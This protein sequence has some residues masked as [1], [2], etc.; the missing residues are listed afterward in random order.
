MR[1]VRKFIPVLVVVVLGLAGLAPAQVI[2]Q[3]PAN[4]MVVL[5]VSNLDATSKKI[6]DLITSMGLGQMSP[7][8]A[9]PLG[10]AQKSMGATEGI[11]KSGELAIV[12]LDPDAV[13]GD[14]SKAVLALLP[15]SDYQAFLG[16]YQGNKTD[17][18]VTEV[19]TPDSTESSFVA[20]WGNYA[21]I[22]QSKDYLSKKPD[23]FIE[24]DG[25]AAK[26]LENKDMV[27][28]ANVKVL[29]TKAGPA[30][31]QARQEGMAELDQFNAGAAGAVP[32]MDPAKLVPVL[33]LGLNQILDASLSFLTQTNFVTYSTNISADGISMT[34]MS[35]FLADSQI[36]KLVVQIKNTEAPLLTGLPDGKYL[37]MAGSVND[38]ALSGQFFDDVISPFAKGITGLGA[39]YAPVN[40]ALDMIRKQI[41]STTGESMGFVAPTGALG[42][43]PL[44][45]FVDIKR[46][47][48]KAMIDIM[49]TAP[50][51]QTAAMKAIGIDTSS[52]KYSLTPSAKHWPAFRLTR[53]RQP[54][55]PLPPGL[56]LRRFR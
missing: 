48:T 52:T 45:Q 25:A 37:F 2:K 12:V 46:G 28:L 36:G 39:D 22:C 26:E 54:W 9:D 3:V 42:Q 35:E 7:E 1:I 30:I 47:D 16:N 56:T 29:R 43:S 10:W 33:K 50:D 14:I 5:K 32:N 18:D 17:G 49:H 53:F 6:S 24:V 51:I 31:D 4:A 34:L 8:L 41:T 23:A 38:P 13:G 19:H 27:L 11:N 44:F 55:I 15:V 40:T 21:A 20:H